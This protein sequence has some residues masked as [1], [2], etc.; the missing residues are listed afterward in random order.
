MEGRLVYLTYVGN[1][2]W[3]RYSGKEHWVGELGPELR[4]LR[5]WGPQVCPFLVNSRELLMALD[6]SQV[7]WQRTRWPW[8]TCAPRERAGP[9]GHL[10]YSGGNRNLK[11]LMSSGVNPKFARYL[12][13]HRTPV[14][15]ASAWAMRTSRSLSPP[16]KSFHFSSC[17]ESTQLYTWEHCLC[18]S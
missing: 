18:E 15:L 1:R 7:W 11:E 12:F 5:L 4:R 9:E 6:G 10:T 2:G 14:V 17:F 13:L 8:Y 16:E 3:L